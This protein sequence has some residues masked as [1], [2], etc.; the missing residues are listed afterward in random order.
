MSD[1]LTENQQALTSE[2]ERIAAALE[3]HADGREPEAGAARAR[4]PVL[5]ALV[6]S[7]RPVAV[8]ARRA[9]PVRGRRARSSLRKPVR[10]GCRRRARPSRVVQPRALMPSRGALERDRARRSAALAPA[11]RAG[12]GRE[13]DHEPVAH[14]RAGAAPPDRARLPRRPAPGAA[15]PGRGARAASALVRGGGVGARHRLL[16]RLG[17]CRA[18]DGP[19]RGRCRVTAG[20]R[21]L[22]LRAAR[23]LRPRPAGGRRAGRRSRA[24]SLLSRVAARVGA[25]GVRPAA[26]SR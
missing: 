6:E 5:E 12:S 9:A 16:G 8:R 4:P 26:R 10:I 23:P 3:A 21:S 14:R 25:H 11:R 22:R 20:R 19:G 2:L 18:R 1:W 15:R 17:H 13:R 7:P 24:G